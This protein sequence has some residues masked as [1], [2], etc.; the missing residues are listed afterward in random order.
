MARRGPRPP[1]LWSLHPTL[2]DDVARL[3]DEDDLHLDFFNVDDEETNIEERDT[4]IVGRFIC[5]NRRCNSSGWSS[6]KVP[7]TIRMY[8]RQ[9]YNARVYHQ[10]C[11]KC[12]VVARPILDRTYAE[13]VAYWIRKWNGIEVERPPISG[14]SSGPHESARCEGCRAGHCRGLNEDLVLQMNR[15]VLNRALSSFH[16]I[17]SL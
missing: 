8:P 6:G 5:R 4:N 7:V 1:V 14:R 3:L 13:R 9:Q 12:D 11:K 2:H 15:W 10:R 16:W 17:N